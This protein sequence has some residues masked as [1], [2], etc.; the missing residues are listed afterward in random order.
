[1]IIVSEEEI[2]KII[3]DMKQAMEDIDNNDRLASELLL[4]A[5]LIDENGQPSEIYQ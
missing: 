5:G 2:Q 4:G 1:M 3:D